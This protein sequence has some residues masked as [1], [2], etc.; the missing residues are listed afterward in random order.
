MTRCIRWR[1][2]KHTISLWHKPHNNP[3]CRPGLLQQLTLRW[4]KQSFLP[5]GIWIA[6]N[7]PFEFSTTETAFGSGIRAIVRHH[8]LT[9]LPQSR[10][11]SLNCTPQKES[12]E[13]ELSKGLK[14]CKSASYPAMMI[15]PLYYV[16]V[17]TICKEALLQSLPWQNH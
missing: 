10:C 9:C 11:R 15:C 1:Q 5:T 17:G 14:C 16:V 13:I 3:R 2:I 8:L 6:I 4:R 7:D 12:E